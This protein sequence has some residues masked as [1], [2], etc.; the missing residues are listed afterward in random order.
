MITV[1]GDSFVALPNDGRLG[2]WSITNGK[3]KDE[4]VHNCRAAF[5]L[6]ETL[7]IKFVW[8]NFWYSGIAYVTRCPEVGST[9]FTFRGTG[10]LVQ[11]VK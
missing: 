9:G 3:V 10:P 6:G 1:V 4:H 7:L 8:D 5:I 11:V 2:E